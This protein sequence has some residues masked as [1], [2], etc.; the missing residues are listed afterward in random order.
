ME[1]LKDSLENLHKVLSKA[2]QVDNDS[3]EL[4]RSLM[5]DIQKLLDKKVEDAENKKHNII[6]D[7]KE[8]AVKFEATHPELSGAINIVITGLSNLGV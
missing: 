2:E 4:L 7:L 3:K 8:S 1:K 6:D 5:F